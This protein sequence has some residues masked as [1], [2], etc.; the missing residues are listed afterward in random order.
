VYK[1]KTSVKTPDNT[2][3]IEWVYIIDFDRS[4]FYETEEEENIYMFEQHPYDDFSF[5]Q[6]RSKTIFVFNMLVKKKIIKTGTRKKY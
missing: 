3:F 2:T 5:E 6:I 4:N 1:Y